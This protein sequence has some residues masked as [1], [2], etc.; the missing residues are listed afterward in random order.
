MTTGTFASPN[1]CP[2]WLSSRVYLP[3]FGT[4]LSKKQDY[5]SW[6]R[7]TW[8]ESFKRTQ[9]LVA[10]FPRPLRRRR[11]DHDT[12]A[13]DVTPATCNNHD[14]QSD[15]TGAQEQA[16]SNSDLAQSILKHLRAQVREQ[17]ITFGLVSDVADMIVRDLSVEGLKQT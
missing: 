2:G 6:P 7:Q 3:A 14:E 12:S 15:A 4:V 16:P 1:V 8:V 11:R 5:A 9:D 10:Q 17:L 13:R